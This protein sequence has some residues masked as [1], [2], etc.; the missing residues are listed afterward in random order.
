MSVCPFATHIKRL[1]MSPA[2]DLALEAEVTFCVQGVLSPVLANLYMNRFLK[3]WRRNGHRDRLHAHVVAYAD[4]LVILTRGHAA[5]AMARLQTAMPRLG[6]KVN[7]AKTTTVDARTQ[8][9][10]FLGYSF[11]AHRTR[12]NGAWYLGA[13]P[14]KTSVQRLKT[15]VRA[16]LV[17]SNTGTWFETRDR[18]NRMLRGWAG[19]F[20]YGTVTPAYRAVDAHVDERAR[21]FLRRRHKVATR[22]TR[23]F[24]TPRLFGDLGVTSLQGR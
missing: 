6:L 5:E 14:S 17:P 16:L 18:L 20:C 15:H 19:Y 2:H 21:H 7:A 13:S 10:D 11:G 3:Y 23:Q 1:V 4:D 22:A 9:F 8:Q 12:R 24:S